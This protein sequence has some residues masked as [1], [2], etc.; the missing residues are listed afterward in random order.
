MRFLEETTIK[1][2]GYSDDYGTEV[3]HLIFAQGVTREMQEEYLEFHGYPTETTSYNVF[4]EDGR[5]CTGEVHKVYVE[6]EG[7]LVTLT[8]LRDI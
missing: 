6:Y 7:R 4:S 2:T 3:L 8:A 1:A 5:D